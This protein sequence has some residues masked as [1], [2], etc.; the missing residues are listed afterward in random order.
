MS[1]TEIGILQTINSNQYYITYKNNFVNLFKSEAMSSVV[2]IKTIADVNKSLNNKYFIL[3][4]PSN[5]YC[6]YF[7]VDSVGVGPQVSSSFSTIEIS[8][9]ENDNANTISTTIKSK[10]DSLY[11]NVFITA[12]DGDE[13]TIT[14]E[15][16]G[17]NDYLTVDGNTNFN[18]S[19]IQNGSDSFSKIKSEIPD[20]K[21]YEILDASVN[22]SGD[23]TILGIYNTSNKTIDENNKPLWS[24]IYFKDTK[25]YS[26]WI[27]F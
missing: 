19:L 12:I 11:S 22:D 17:K 6:I 14:N 21:L 3:S 5:S 4:T 13:L 26:S 27:N 18:I 20:E 8:I 7:N 1:N 16:T 2:K 15:E 24:N 23:L 10:L 9:S 25:T